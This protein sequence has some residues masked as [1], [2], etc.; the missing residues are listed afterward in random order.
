MECHFHQL[1][2]IQWYLKKFKECTYCEKKP[3]TLMSWF[4]HQKTYFLTSLLMN[5][6]M[7]PPRNTASCSIDLHLLSFP[8]YCVCS[9]FSCNIVLL[10]FAASH[11]W[12]YSVSDSTSHPTYL[13][14]SCSNARTLKQSKVIPSFSTCVAVI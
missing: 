9:F 1:L 14:I 11:P 5:F 2:N 3:C 6:L 13:N 8:S 7:F 4:L 12:P 10:T